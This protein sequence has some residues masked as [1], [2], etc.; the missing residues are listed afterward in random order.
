M[1]ETIVPK[2]LTLPQAAD[3]LAVSEHSVR[4]WI[5]DGSLPAF[6][7]GPGGHFRI[8]EPDLAAFRKPVRDK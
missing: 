3:V 4:N 8:A 5:K 6:R 2:H 1:Q 7:V